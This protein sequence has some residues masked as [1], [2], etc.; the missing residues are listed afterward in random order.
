MLLKTGRMMDMLKSDAA[1]RGVGLLMAIPSSD[2]VFPE[3]RYDILWRGWRG[4]FLP[5]H[6]C[7]NLIKKCC[8]ERRNCCL[9]SCATDCSHHRHG[10]DDCLCCGSWAGEPGSLRCAAQ[11]R[12]P[13]TSQDV[14]LFGFGSRQKIERE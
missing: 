14:N 8:L 11:L 2:D 3:Y 1:R 12:H 4:H 10:D 5:S 9:D 13:P 7:P 6:H